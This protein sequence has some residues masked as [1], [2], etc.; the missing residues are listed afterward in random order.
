MKL[1]HSQMVWVRGLKTLP[2]P[3]SITAFVFGIVPLWSLFFMHRPW[4]LFQS[5][6]H[7]KAAVLIFNFWIGPFALAMC[8]LTR[9]KFLIPLF[10][11]ESC[12]MLLQSMFKLTA[13]SHEL[14]LLQLVLIGALILFTLFLLNTDALYP[15]MHGASRPWRSKR[16][17]HV[18][19]TAQIISHDG[20]RIAKV[21]VQNCSLSGMQFSG[22]ATDLRFVL[23]IKKK[24]DQAE[25]ALK[26]KGKEF[27][28]SS[29][30]SWAREED[31]EQFYG[32][33][34]AD[35]KV[36]AAFIQS[37]PPK[38][39]E[40]ANPILQHLDLYWQKKQVR[41]VAISLWMIIILGGILGP[42]AGKHLTLKKQASSLGDS[43]YVKA[44]FGPT[45]LHGR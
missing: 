38:Y 13:N 22:Q 12:T 44:E 20:S 27:H 42:I 8:A 14:T 41:Q 17:R 5:V 3:L 15:L 32:I 35:R 37:L 1:S 10:V 18:G 11:T 39:E 33:R 30:V 2:G 40:H 9:H 45:F 6:A 7:W 24:H 16:R 34:V 4:A 21:V 23:S 31:G 25:F 26:V 29:T 36:M 28:F 19:L 43:N